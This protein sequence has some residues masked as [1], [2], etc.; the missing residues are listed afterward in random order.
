MEL[1]RSILYLEPCLVDGIENAKAENGKYR[2]EFS[3]DDLAESLEAL[4]YSTS[5]THSYSKR[6]QLRSLYDKIKSYLALSLGLPR[7]RL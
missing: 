6:E 2:V 4:S 7:S 3:D 5:Y 1:L